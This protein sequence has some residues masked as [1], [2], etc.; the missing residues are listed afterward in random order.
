MTESAVNSKVVRNDDR[1]RYEI[2]FDGE[3]AGFAEYEERDNETVFT[4]TEVD[5][6]FSGKGLGSSL[7]AGAVGDAAGRGRA[8]RPECQFIR[9]YLDKHSEYDSQ[10]VGTDQAEGPDR[11]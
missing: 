3:I 10:V 4:Y 5:Q 8:I 7:A 1:S 9:S 11:E 2:F 6:A